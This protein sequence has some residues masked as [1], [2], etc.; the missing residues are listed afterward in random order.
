MLNLVGGITI[1]K[2]RY[3]INVSVD[4]YI[5]NVYDASRKRVENIWMMVSFM[6]D[7]KINL[8][9]RGCS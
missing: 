5:Y 9:T 1:S 2:S 3:I 7:P 8:P 4:I 6:Q